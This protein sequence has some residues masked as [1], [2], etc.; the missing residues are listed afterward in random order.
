MIRFA[1][2]LL[3][4]QTV[5]LCLTSCNSFRCIEISVPYDFND[6]IYILK[7]IEE[8]ESYLLLETRYDYPN[9]APIS[10]YMVLFKMNAEKIK[11]KKGRKYHIVT[12]PISY[13]SDETTKIYYLSP[14]EK[15]KKVVLKGYWQQLYV[16]KEIKEIKETGKKK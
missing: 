4:V 16:V 6:S 10:Q 2:L 3:K 9:Y 1:L 5:L 12:T 13:P 7:S 8:R 11:L 15:D 14:N